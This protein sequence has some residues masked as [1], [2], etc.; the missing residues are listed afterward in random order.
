MLSPWEQGIVELV[1]AT[2][3]AA[4]SQVAK[5]PR[6]K[7]KIKSLVRAEIL[8]RVRLEGAYKLNVL[9]PGPYPGLEEVLKSLCLTRLVLILRERFARV[10]IY[11]S[12]PYRAALIIN[13][14]PYHVLVHRE[15]EPVQPVIVLANGAERS[16]VLVEKYHR[17]FSE[18]K[19]GRILL[20][21]EDRFL[22]PDGTPEP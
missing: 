5:T 21:L 15:G 2:G 7:K 12:P 16:I 3:A 17:E 8:G 11:P 14:K 22:L 19:K 18:I 9:L 10:E 20:D 4:Y 1:R 13:E 6:E